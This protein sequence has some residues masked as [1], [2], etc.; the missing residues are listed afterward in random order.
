VEN[1]ANQFLKIVAKKFSVA[2]SGTESVKMKTMKLLSTCTFTKHC[3]DLS[4]Y[5]YNQAEL[6][7]HFSN[8]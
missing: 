5:L 4:R 3:I 1:S 7:H 6:L 2:K 8:F